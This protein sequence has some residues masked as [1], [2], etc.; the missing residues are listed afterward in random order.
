M[1]AHAREKKKGH[2]LGRRSRPVTQK[3]LIGRPAPCCRRR[4]RPVKAQCM[5]RYVSE[6]Q[7][8]SPIGLTDQYVRSI[9][10]CQSVLLIRELSYEKKRVR[11]SDPIA[12]SAQCGVPRNLNH[13]PVETRVPHLS[14]K[15]PPPLDGRRGQNP[16]PTCSHTHFS[17]ATTTA[18]YPFRVPAAPRAPGVPPCNRSPSIASL[19]V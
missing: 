5:G 18:V 9:G 14:N 19:G 11:E 16:P 12:Q 6:E 2:R 17:F 4:A 3:K 15:I 8:R 1:G 7:F 13:T 10:A